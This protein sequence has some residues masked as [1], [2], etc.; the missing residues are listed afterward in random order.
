MR[1][2]RLASDEE[3]HDFTRTFKDGINAAITHEALERNRF[4]TTRFQR[5][6]SLITP[7]TSDLNGLIDD[8]PRLF[9]APH[10]AHGG[11]ETDIGMLIAIDFAGRKE[12]H[13]FDRKGIGGHPPD[14]VSNGSVFANRRP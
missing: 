13:G 2:E 10:L 1:I 12:S 14:F 5:R 9:T 7:A 11:F 6:R 8:L 4:F 3:A